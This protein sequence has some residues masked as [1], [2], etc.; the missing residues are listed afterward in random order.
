MHGARMPAWGC[1]R[2]IAAMAGLA[3][4]GG[5]SILR[6]RQADQT[7]PGFPKGAQRSQVRGLGG[8]V[9]VLD[10]GDY[11]VVQRHGLDTYTPA[12]RVDHVR[13]LSAIV[14]AGCDR[15]LAVSS[16]GSL[17]AELAVGAVLA[18]DDFIALDQPATSVHHDARSHVVPAFSPEWRSQVLGAWR[19]QSEVAIGDGGV[20]WQ[21]NGPRF[22]T[23]SEVRYLAAFADVVGMTVGSECVIANELGLLYAA[24]CIVDNLANGLG[25]SPLTPAEFAAGKAANA[26]R[27]HGALH[28]VAPVLA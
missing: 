17:R 26:A 5:H 21:S 2:T 27:L 24:V 28:A 16:V 15:V 4:V 6:E 7:E 23:P 13:N 9:T 14:A 19:E 22:E 1:S 20:Y 25:S 11:L 8:D 3:V 10:T 18:P 12:H